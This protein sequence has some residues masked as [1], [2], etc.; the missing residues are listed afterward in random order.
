MSNRKQ[1]WVSSVLG[2]ALEAPAQSSNDA[3]ASSPYPSN[4][5]VLLRAKSIWISDIHLGSRDCKAEFLLNFLNQIH[6]DTLYLVGDIVDMWA[7]KRRFRWPAQH[8]QVL[9]KFYELANRGVRVIYLPGNHDDPMRRFCGDT[10]GPVEIAHECIHFAPNG[11]R[12]LVMHGDAMEAYVNHSWVTKLIGHHGYNL[13]LFINRW[14]NQLRKWTG[15]PYYSL[16]G[17]IKNNL[18]GARK[19]VEKY[20]QAAIDEARERGFDGVICGHIHQAA[21]RDEQGFYYANTGDWVESC[22]AL[23]EDH[24]GQLRLLD[25][26]GQVSWKDVSLKRSLE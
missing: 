4:M 14:S 13:L 9:L 25:F 11:K 12:Y 2:E 21:L 6:C 3:P 8:Y 22:T 26:N 15:Q 23:F 10:F 7:M 24:H 20:E 19:A 5:V 18:K 1:S 17:S 16:A